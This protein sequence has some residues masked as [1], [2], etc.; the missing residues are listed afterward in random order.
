MGPAS[1]Q[2]HERQPRLPF[3]SPEFRRQPALLLYLGHLAAARVPCLRA[4]RTPEKGRGCV[5]CKGTRLDAGVQELTT[6]AWPGLCGACA[7]TIH[8]AGRPIMEGGQDVSSSRPRTETFLNCAAV[9]ESKSRRP[10]GPTPPTA[11]PRRRR[12]RR[13][14]HSMAHRT[15]AN[16]GVSRGKMGATLFT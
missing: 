16:N 4:I 8:L 7:E 2:V 9:T 11:T 15:C 6:A 5:A 3:C 14:K 10:A 13:A 1:A 12:R